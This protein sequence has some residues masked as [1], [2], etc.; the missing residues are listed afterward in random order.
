MPKI[1]YLIAVSHIVGCFIAVVPLPARPDNQTTHGNQSP[2]TGQVQGN[3]TIITG[4]GRQIVNQ[5]GPSWKAFLP[6][7]FSVDDDGFILNKSGKRICETR[8]TESPPEYGIG[9]VVSHSYSYA[10]Y[11]QLFNGQWKHVTDGWVW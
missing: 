8:E 1:S 6:R 5:P 11:C 2:S 10:T 3:Q 4:H 9:G 7:G